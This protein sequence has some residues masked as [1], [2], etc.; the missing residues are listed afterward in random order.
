MIIVVAKIKRDILLG[1]ICSTCL[2]KVRATL[3]DEVPIWAEQK[4]HLLIEGLILI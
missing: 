1:K 2:L 3:P 4:N